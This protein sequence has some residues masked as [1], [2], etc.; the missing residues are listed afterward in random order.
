MVQAI[1]NIFESIIL[2]IIDEM[3][4]YLPFIEN[5]TIKSVEPSAIKNDKSN[6]VKRS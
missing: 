4:P 1:W 2:P 6:Y 3:V 5:A